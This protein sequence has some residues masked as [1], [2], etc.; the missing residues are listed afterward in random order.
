MFLFVGL[1]LQAVWFILH[2]QITVGGEMKH[3]RQF[4]VAAL[5]AVAVL[6]LGVSSCGDDN[7][8][9][10]KGKLNEACSAD[11]PCD[12]GLVCSD[13]GKC[14]E[15]NSQ[16]PA[17]NEKAKLGEDCDA[18]KVCDDG[19][20][21]GDEGKCVKKEGKPSEPVE[22][23]PGNINTDPC[24]DAN[25]PDGTACLEGRCYDE[26]CIDNGSLKSCEDGQMCA[27]GVCIDDGCQDKTCGDGE[28][29][30]KGICEDELCFKGAIVCNAGATCVKGACVDN[31]CLSM[32]CD[33]G[34]TCVKG[35]CVFPACVGK[36]ACT[37]GKICNEAGDCVYE[38]AP[39]LNVTADDKETDEYGDM[40]AVGLSLN[41]PPVADVTVSCEI[42]SDSPV[43]EA[44]VN[45]DAILFNADNY[46][47][48]QSITVI[49]VA[50]NKIDADQNFKLTITTKSDDADFNGLVQSIDMVNK[51]V[52]T[53]GVKISGD[54]L[55]T[56][57]NGGSASF[58]VSLIAKPAADVTI[59]I[60]SSNP[61]YG[62]LEGAEENVLTVTFTPEDWDTPKEITVK[63]VDDDAPNGEEGHNYQIT[64]SVASEDAEYNG[65]EVKPI[66]VINIDNDVKDVFLDKSSIET[67]E[68][69]EAVAITA[70]LGLEPV[71]DVKVALKI[72]AE[73]K[74]A[75]SAEADI[76]GE[77]EIV[78]NKD[79]YK[80]GVAFSVKGMVDNKIDGDQNYFVRLRISSNDDDTYDNLADKFIPGKN[81]DADKADL[82]LTYTDTMVTEAGSTVDIGVALMSIP[83]APVVIR[84]NSSNNEEMTV[85]PAELEF[86]AENWNIP[87][88]VTVTG[89]DDVIDDGDQ[90]SQ[91]GFALFTDDKDYAALESLS[92]D[93]T[94]Q[95]NDAA[96][97]VVI[98]VGRDIRE[99]SKETVEFKVVLGAQPQDGK[100][101]VRA[102][103]SD[104]SE[105]K[106]LGNDT[107]SF[108]KDSWNTPQSFVLQ[109]QDD[110]YADG[111]QVVRVN[112]ESSSSDSLFNGL[113]ANTENYNIL[114]NESAS[115][116]LTAAKTMFKPGDEYTTP[117]TV[118]LSAPPMGDVTVTINTT[119]ATT[120]SIDKTTLT[121]TT[122]NWSTPQT[123]TMASKD[124]QAA[125]AAKTVEVISAVTTGQGSYNNLQSNAVELTMY[126]FISK[127]FAYT[128]AVQQIDLLPGNYR[129]QVWGAKGGN[130]TYAGA[131]GGYSVGDYK[132]AD[133]N[134][135]YVYVGGQGAACATNAGGGWN[136]GGN[137]G[138]IGCSGG[139][140]G[141]TDIRTVGGAWNLEASLDSRIIVAG[142]GGGGGNTTSTCVGGVGGGTNG[143]GNGSTNYQGKGGTQTAGYAKGQGGNAPQDGAGGGGGLWGGF[144]SPG[145]DDGGGGGSG[146]ISPNLTSAS[147][148]AG[149][150]AFPNTAG[151]GTETG[152]AASGY[153][154]ITLID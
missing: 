151:S 139:G 75:T 106:L 135:L 115:V 9:V 36:E 146:Y 20:E 144:G 72:M 55:V 98:S 23:D 152:H 100:V 149:N 117:I 93:I 148:I 131:N 76:V 61:Q 79:N 82:R 109:V 105:L 64:F 5:C 141:A 66:S 60:A 12:A 69:G 56:T 123:I 134:P 127:D 29:C 65:I 11:K 129:L 153:A 111:T 31:E 114:D 46:S 84:L 3:S 154:R 54:N 80:D 90:I 26:E 40:A 58:S 97:I 147:T 102:K 14:V 94:T 35:D 107:V 95:D 27:K 48:A 37:G 99:D 103:S 19:L 33:G 67:I 63:G 121:F 30:H 138:P 21:C 108:D 39:A 52:D 73:D 74:S 22:P 136:G 1:R 45:C 78:L 122:E 81:I 118:A 2:V 104:E 32:S 51:N 132:K 133:K 130:D 89:Q 92:L 77:K 119:N 57:E 120:A 59:T 112:L 125:S 140:G 86:T 25:C 38:V 87:Q 142:G 96:E 113:K 128:G 7:A 6:G 53:V 24:K 28:I 143:G 34:L 145:Y 110:N 8:A 41:H 10:S 68:G 4:S 13:E 71:G 116:T 44:E 91:L 42:T 43:P 83:T 126:A 70:R 16:D 17:D 137:A 50:D 18:E 88:T 15:A 150:A 124:P 49:G 62:V 47:E 85:A 101:I